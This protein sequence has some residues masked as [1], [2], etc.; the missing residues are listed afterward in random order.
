[1][2]FQSGVEQ[3]LVCVVAGPSPAVDL[4][5]EHLRLHIVHPIATNHPPF[6]IKSRVL[7]FAWWVATLIVSTINKEKE[8]KG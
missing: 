1:M 8:K 7:C 4:L 5:L 2:Q 3:L 6:P